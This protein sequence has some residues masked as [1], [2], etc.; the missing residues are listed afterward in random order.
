M[1]KILIIFIFLQNF[2]LFCYG[3]ITAANWP[4]GE[5]TDIYTSTNSITTSD[6]GEYAQDVASI[7]TA[8]I[9]IWGTGQYIL[10]TEYGANDC[11]GTCLAS[12]ELY[13]DQDYVELGTGESG[14]CTHSTQVLV[15]QHLYNQRVNQAMQ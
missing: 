2:S 7:S 11:H 5:S 12:G 6:S 14:S 1:L 13:K 4:N 8:T 9:G 10:T 15:Y 3:L